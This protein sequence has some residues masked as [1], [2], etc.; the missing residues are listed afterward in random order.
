M[1]CGRHP[2]PLVPLIPQFIEQGTEHI[3][4]ERVRYSAK[5]EMSMMVFDS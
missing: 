4:G 2:C 3:V 5:V 1:S